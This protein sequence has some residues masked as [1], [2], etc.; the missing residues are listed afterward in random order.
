MSNLSIFYRIFNSSFSVVPFLFF[1][2]NIRDHPCL[3]KTIY[4]FDCRPE[5]NYFA[6]GVLVHNK[7]ILPPI[8]PEAQVI[9]PKNDAD[10]LEDRHIFQGRV[11]DADNA[12]EERRKNISTKIRNLYTN[13]TYALWL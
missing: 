13:T 11:Y 8:P 6:N 2:S 1:I 3:D 10:L 9:Y 7:S 5:H 12:F 4:D